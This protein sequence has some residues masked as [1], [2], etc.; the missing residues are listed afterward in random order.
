MP[1]VSEVSAFVTPDTFFQYTVMHFRLH[2]VPATFQRSMHTV[3]GGVQYCEM[4]INDVVLY[5]S[6]WE[7]HMETLG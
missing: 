1:C 7:E 6:I 2:D 4:Y 3:L 5:S